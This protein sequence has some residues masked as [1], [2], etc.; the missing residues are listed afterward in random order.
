MKR[1]ITNAGLLQIFLALLIVMMAMFVSNYIVHRNSIAGIYDK[2]SQNNTLVVKTMIQSFD[3]S[4]RTID[5]LIHSIHALPYNNVIEA[6]GRTDMAKIYDLQKNVATLVSSI[7]FIEDVVV[8][9]DN[10]DLAVTLYGTSSLTEIFDNKYKHDLYDAAYWKEYSASPRAGKVFT[11]ETFSIQS[12]VINQ[13]KKKDLMV[14]TAGNKVRLSDKNIM[15]LVDAEEW[16]NYVDQNATIPGSSFIVLDPNRNVIMSTD[17]GFDLVEVLNDVYFNISEEQSVTRKNF[18]YNIYR[19]D[20]ND[21]IYIDKV[22]YQF[23]NIDSVNKA[24]QTIMI[25]AIISTVILSFL[26]SIYLYK[27]VKNILQQ[28]DIGNYK[29]NDFLNIHKGILQIQTEN[30]RLRDQLNALDREIRRAAFLRSLDEYAEPSDYEHLLKEYLSGFY[31]HK[32]FAMVLI[33]LQS[34]ESDWNRNV[35]VEEMGVMLAGGLKQELFDVPVFHIGGLYFVALVGLEGSAARHTLFKQLRSFTS[36]MEKG[37]KHYTIWSCVSKLYASEAANFKQAYRDVSNG[38]IYRN[39]NDKVSVTDVEQIEYTCGIY[40]PL[41]KMEKLCNYLLS[42]KVTDAVKIVT[43]TIQENMNRN[44]HWHQLQHVAKAMFYDMLRYTGNS[45]ADS[46]AL[47]QLEMDFLLQLEGAAHHSDMERALVMVAKYLATQSKGEQK[48]KL[49][50]AFISQYI[51]LHYMENLYLDRMA[52][53]LGTSP[54][55]FSNYFKKTFGVNYVEYLNKVRLFHARELL[56]DS[57]LT[58]AEVGE[59]TGYQNSSTFTTTFKKYFGISPSDYRK[60]T[61]LK[62][63]GV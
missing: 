27:P 56:R 58:I 30:K 41:E 28:L 61:V 46:K 50:P 43:E 60:K 24:N 20:Y 4:F 6:D 32:Q 1:L 54:K 39:V 59:K 29:G 36:R 63:F 9:Y 11:T 62:L 2:V 51:N 21:F 53:V 38:A 3:N 47:Y 55:Y 25:T 13:K 8:F 42:K 23:M 33:H 37:L 15:L 44:I 52:E 17:Q 26:L 35:H 31:S 14:V 7:D 12:E 34:R 45:S 19:S 18:E 5:R 48:S 22:P 49:D 16:M 40:Y 10:M 57:N